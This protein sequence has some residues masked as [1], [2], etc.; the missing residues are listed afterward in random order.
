MKQHKCKGCLERHLGCHSYCKSYLDFVKANK[1]DKPFKSA[2]FEYLGDRERK[3]MR[4]EMSR[5]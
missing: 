4:K 2:F 3:R 1:K 5:R